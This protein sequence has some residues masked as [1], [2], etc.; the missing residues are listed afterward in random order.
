[1][2]RDECTE[3]IERLKKRLDRLRDE[4]ARQHCRFRAGDV[5]SNVR[6]SESDVWYMGKRLKVLRVEPIDDLPYF[7]VVVN[8]AS[9]VRRG[10][11]STRPFRLSEQQYRQ[12]EKQ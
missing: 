6:P 7:S 5:L 1:M 11:W 4:R 3:Q 12:L 10:T 8:V 2:I 9:S